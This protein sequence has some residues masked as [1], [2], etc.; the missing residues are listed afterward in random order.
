MQTKE[1]NIFGKKALFSLEEILSI[2]PEDVRLFP[3]L[4]TLNNKSV[5]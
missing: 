1:W 5:N 2:A 3:T 4:I